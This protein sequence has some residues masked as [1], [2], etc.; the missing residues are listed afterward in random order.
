MDLSYTVEKLMSN[1]E[2]TS[3]RSPIHRKFMTKVQTSG[4]NYVDVRFPRGY[5]SKNKQRH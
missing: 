2:R 5:A 1:K 4:L 3:I